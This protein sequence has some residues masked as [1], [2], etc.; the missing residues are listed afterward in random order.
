MRSVFWP[1]ANH[2]SCPFLRMTGGGTI[3]KAQA[4]EMNK[5]IRSISLIHRRIF[6]TGMKPHFRKFLPN[7]AES[8]NVIVVCVRDENMAEHE[9][10]FFDHLQNWL[11]ILTCIQQ[12][13]FSPE[14][15]PNELTIS[16][17]CFGSGGERTQPP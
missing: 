10:V 8:G 12:R 17:H 9:L 6:G 16:R 7:A 1:G 5:I 2:V 3:G 15:R 14:L 13:G 4:A 11:S